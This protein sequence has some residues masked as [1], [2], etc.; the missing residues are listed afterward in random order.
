[1]LLSKIDWL[2]ETNVRAK[3]CAIEDSCF[4]VIETEAISRSIAYK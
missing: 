2:L 4:Y 3:V 1:M